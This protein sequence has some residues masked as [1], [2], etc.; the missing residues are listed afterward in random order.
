[1]D[2]EKLELNADFED[3]SLGGRSRVFPRDALHM[4]W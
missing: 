2:D 3:V 1:M 4:H